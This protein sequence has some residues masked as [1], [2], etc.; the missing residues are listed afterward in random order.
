MRKL[1]RTVLSR[2][3]LR[4]ALASVMAV[5]VLALTGFPAAGQ[6]QGPFFEELVPPIEVG[7]HSPLNLADLTWR[8]GAGD[9]SDL[10]LPA[11]DDEEWVAGSAVNP[12]LLRNRVA[13]YRFHFTIAPEARGMGSELLLGGVEGNAAIYLNGHLLGRMRGAVYPL[14]RRQ[15]T[16]GLAPALLRYDSDNV[17]AIRL[18]GFTGQPMVGIPVGPLAMAAFS[19]SLPWPGPVAATAS[20][21]VPFGRFGGGNLTGLL[22]CELG[23]EGFAAATTSLAP[24][25]LSGTFGSPRAGDQV[26]LQSLSSVGKIALVRQSQ[27]DRYRVFYPLLYPGFALEP[28]DATLSVHLAGNLDLRYVDRWG[29]ATHRARVNA[30]IPWVEPWLCLYDPRARRAPLLVSLPSPAW[31]IQL[32]KTRSGVDLLL[33]AGAIARFCWPWGIAPHVPT[34]QPADMARIRHWADAMVPF[35][36]HP[37][38]RIDSDG[39]H[40]HDRFGYLDAGAIPYAPLAPVIGLALGHGA[41]LPVAIARASISPWLAKLLGSEPPSASP[42]AHD[43]GLPTLAGP[44]WAA[45]GSDEIAYDLPVPSL[46]RPRPRAASASI[47]LPRLPRAMARSAADLAFTNRAWAYLHWDQLSATDRRYL[48]ANSA[49]QIKRAWSQASWA[50]STE[51]VTG[52]EFA[53]TEAR[54]EGPGMVGSPA[55]AGRYESA[56]S[57]STSMLALSDHLGAYGLGNGLALYGTSMAALYG[58]DWSLVKAA[59]PAMQQAFDWFPDAFDWAWQSACNS[60]RGLSTGDGQTLTAGYLG[61]LGLARMAHVVAPEEQDRY[62][63]L[64]ARMAVLVGER[65]AL[66]TWA[67]QEGLLRKGQVAFGLSRDGVKAATSSAALF[68]SLSDLPDVRALPLDDPGWHS[69]PR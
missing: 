42:A 54:L 10:A 30:R 41:E 59:W 29:I 13:W 44:L 43:L 39:L 38:D 31:T 16:F 7:T 23:P 51:P 66:S 65:P 6:D 56:G 5:W 52:T 15:E 22:T 11:Y 34:D 48:Q 68:G 24:A 33:P 18:S 37:D 63:A 32:K 19:P 67:I 46:D 4:A 14:Y 50:R 49:Y 20:S 2:P 26:K 25:P 47:A 1:N 9:G 58:Q 69:S 45:T 53:W 60:E 3:A 64:A 61:A 35:A 62:L 36:L 21:S 57:E 27:G 28:L 55:S 12:E 8:L 17:I 40:A